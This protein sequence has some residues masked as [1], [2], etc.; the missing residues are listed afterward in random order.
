M[1]EQV[2]VH[3]HICSGITCGRALKEEIYTRGN[4]KFIYLGLYLF[5]ELFPKDFSSLACITSYDS[6]EIFKKQFCK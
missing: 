6:R 5:T 3:I 4:Q 1:S 2:A